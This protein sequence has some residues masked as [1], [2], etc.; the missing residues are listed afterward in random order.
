MI[1]LDWEICWYRLKLQYSDQM[2]KEGALV[3]TIFNKKP[4]FVYFRQRIGFQEPLSAEQKEQW[5]TGC[6]PSL[7]IVYDAQGISNTKFYAAIKEAELLWKS[8]VDKIL[9]MFFPIVFPDTEDPLTHA[10]S[11]PPM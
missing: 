3:E 5:M 10:S 8:H 7:V 2:I 6:I 11:C 4:T 9:F 1:Q